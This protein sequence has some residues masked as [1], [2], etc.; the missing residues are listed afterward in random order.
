[1]FSRDVIAT[2]QPGE[3]I[4]PSEV[5]GVELQYMNLGRNTAKA[6]TETSKNPFKTTYQF[7][8]QTL[9]IWS[10]GLPVCRHLDSESCSLVFTCSQLSTTEQTTV[11][12]HPEVSILNVR[13]HGSPS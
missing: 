6:I 1:M 13:M 11:L 9:L 12:P 4:Q 3:L 8:F 5:L 7:F 10:M 2:Y